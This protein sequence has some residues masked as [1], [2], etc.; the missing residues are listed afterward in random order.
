M[1]SLSKK[2]T[3]VVFYGDQLVHILVYLKSWDSMVV[4]NF[5]FRQDWVGRKVTGMK[6]TFF[7]IFDPTWTQ[8]VQLVQKWGPHGPCPKQNFF[9]PEITKP[10][11]KLS[12]AFDFNKI[13]Y[14]FIVGTPTLLKGGRTFQ[15]LSHLREGGGGHTK[16]LYSLITFTVWGG[17]GGGSKAPFITFWIFSLLS[18][19]FKTLIQVFIVLKPGIIC[20]FLIHSGSLH[21]GS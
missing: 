12:K 20:T 2:L 5:L 17:G 1:I 11:P 16:L 8:L 14:I 19:P 6:K 9:F 21:S 4:K 3:F 10:D 18:Y 7:V 15:K 13:S